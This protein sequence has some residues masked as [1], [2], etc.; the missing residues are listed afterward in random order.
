MEV[1]RRGLDW[2]NRH[3]VDDMGLTVEGLL[4]MLLVTLHVLRQFGLLDSDV[5]I[6][7]ALILDRFGAEY[8]HDLIQSLDT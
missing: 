5:V 4:E 2:L 6:G 8:A 3:V 7:L 1:M